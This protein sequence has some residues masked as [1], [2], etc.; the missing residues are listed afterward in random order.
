MPVEDRSRMLRRIVTPLLTVVVVLALL[1]VALWAGQ[2]RL[3]YLPMGVVEPPER[4]GL[5]AAEQVTFRTA[6]GVDLGAWFV[7]AAA[8]PPR[9]TVIVFNGNAGNRSYRAALASAL[10]RAGYSVLLFDYRGFGGNPG[11][12]S[13]AGLLEDARAARRYLVG[14]RE[15]DSARLVYFGESLGT[16]V[17]VALALEHRPAALVLR[18]PYTSMVAVARVHYPFV[19]AGWILKDRYPSIERIGR[20]GTATLFIAGE[21]D[22]I[23]PPGLTRELYAAASEPRELLVI[24]GADHNDHAM[25]AGD[26]LIGAVT[27]FL[28][29]TLGGD[30]APPR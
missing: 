2:R 26:A 18:S 19:P 22:A 5:A 17:A 11:S 30:L 21:R 14:R 24:P 9:G 25:L 13:E 8:G 7:P 12:P 10:R 16:G 27:S 6:D 28:A 15:V 20:V 3:M 29:R 4:V 1:L 23:V